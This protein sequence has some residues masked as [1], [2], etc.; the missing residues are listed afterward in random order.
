MLRRNVVHPSRIRITL[1]KGPT[2]RAIIEGVNEPVYNG[3]HGGMQDAIG[4]TLK[5][6]MPPRSTTSWERWALVRQAMTYYI[7]H[8]PAAQSVVGCIDI[9]DEL[10][11]AALE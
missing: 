10:G 11:L 2:G 5:K 4:W 7:K 9:Q 6:S 1:K 8:C 3:V